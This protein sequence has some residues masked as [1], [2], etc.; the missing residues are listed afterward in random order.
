MKCSL[1]SKGKWSKKIS[2]A[3]MICVSLAGVARAQSK[4]EGK[5]NLPKN[6]I[7]IGYGVGDVFNGFIYG[8]GTQIGALGRY[9]YTDL[10]IAQLSYA[11]LLNSKFDVG[12]TVLY[13]RG[14]INDRN[15]VRIANVHHLTAMVNGKFYHLNRKSW[16]LYSGIDMGMQYSTNGIRNRKLRQFQDETRFAFHLTGVGIKGGEKIGGFAEVGYGDKGVF[17]AGAYIRF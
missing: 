3:A 16:R 6:E 13:G 7:R 12:G 14:R 10:G 11:R 15:N 8:A 4:H 9:N 2:L 1:V 5:D 17:S